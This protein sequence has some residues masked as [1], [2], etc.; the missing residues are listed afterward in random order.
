M[1]AYSARGSIDKRNSLDLLARRSIDARSTCSSVDCSSA[2]ANALVGPG[3]TR[4]LSFSSSSSSNAQ[5]CVADSA[6]QQAEEERVK[7]GGCLL[8]PAACAIFPTALATPLKMLYCIG[9][10][11]IGMNSNCR[12]LCN[13]LPLLLVH[14]QCNGS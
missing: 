2:A 14:C 5:G 7:L 8:R 1:D 3:W 6:E 12:W 9:S 10:V 4:L 13:L 11:C